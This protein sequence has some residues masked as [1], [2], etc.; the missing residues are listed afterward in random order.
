MGTKSHPLTEDLVA[1][2]GCWEK[3]SLIVRSLVYMYIN[4]QEQL[5][6]GKT[7]RCWVRRSGCGGRPGRGWG[8]G[9][10]MIKKII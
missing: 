8:R 10:D 2:D 3:C 7:E 4:C 1:S 5:G 9:V 6:L